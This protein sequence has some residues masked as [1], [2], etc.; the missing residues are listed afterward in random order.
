MVEMGRKKEHTSSISKKVS[1]LFTRAHSQLRMIECLRSSAK[2]DHVNTRVITWERHCARPVWK[3]QEGLG[4]NQYH[5][6]WRHTVRRHSTPP[7]SHE[8]MK[9]GETWV[10]VK[11]N[12]SM[13]R[14]RE[15]KHQ[16]LPSLKKVGRRRA[17]YTKSSQSSSATRR[18]VGC[19]E[20]F[21]RR[22]RRTPKAYND[23]ETNMAAE[24]VCVCAGVGK[25]SS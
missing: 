17:G 5:S 14:E 2:D 21:L 4:I 13:E 7:H 22:R 8:K 24:R 25:A 11:T 1:L 15:K 12:A 3:M 16:L 9:G 20:P 6:R 19:N 18:G 23:D 10:I